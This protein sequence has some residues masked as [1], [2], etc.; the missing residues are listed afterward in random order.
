M[1]LA[2]AGLSGAPPSDSYRYR[3]G[4]AAQTERRHPV[5]PWAWTDSSWPSSSTTT[6]REGISKARVARNMGRTAVLSAETVYVRRVLPV[7]ALQ[8]LGRGFHSDHAALARGAMVAGPAFTATGFLKVRWTRPAGPPHEVG[9]T[10]RNL[11]TGAVAESVLPL[12]IDVTVDQVDAQLRA[13]RQTARHHRAGSRHQAVS[14]RACHPA[15][16]QPSGQHTATSGPAGRR[17]E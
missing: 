12:V 10:L 15:F 17:R 2:R 16:G 11:T 9:S 7:G 13:G 4:A 1:T 5:R 6:C 14:L 8:N 3:A